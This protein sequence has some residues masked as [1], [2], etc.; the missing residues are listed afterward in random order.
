MRDRRMCVAL[1]HTED[2]PKGKTK[3][4]RDGTGGEP[5]MQAPRGIGWSGGI[6]RR[7]DE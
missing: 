2:E 4:E 5:A 6:V 7:A 1:P 3:T